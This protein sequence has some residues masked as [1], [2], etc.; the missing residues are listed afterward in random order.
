M[1]FNHVS[2]CKIVLVSNDKGQRA[3]YVDGQLL[4]QGKKISITDILRALKV[5]H[6]TIYYS[7]KQMAHM[8][9]KFPDKVNDLYKKDKGGIEDEPSDTTKH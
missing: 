3:V 9:G 2:K 8:D 5:T 4:I 1:N 7:S 6:S